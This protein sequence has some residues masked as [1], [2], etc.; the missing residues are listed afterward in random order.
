MS[1]KGLFLVSAEDRVELWR[2]NDSG[3]SPVGWAEIK[4]TSLSGKGP[5]SGSFTDARSS[6]GT[7]WYGIHVVDT[8]GQ[9]SPEPSPPGPIKV[10]VG[11]FEVIVDDLNSG[12]SKYG[13]PSYWHE[14]SIGYNGH[15]F[16]TYNNQSTID[17]YSRW[18]P[19]LSTGGAGTYAVYVYIPNN[20]ANTTNATYTIFHNG[21]V[22]T[23]AIN[24]N[25]YYNQWVLLGSFYFS[26]NGSEY[27]QLVDKT[28][29]TAVTKMIGFD[30][31]KWVK[32]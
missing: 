14:A 25:I 20:Y 26:A 31:V 7:Y 15:M 28:G 27:V 18:Q 10:T 32:Q 21:A 4:R 23:R 9:W 13:T 1:T 19:N 30:A 16:W 5:S 8:K 2:A 11:T 22:D 17:N 29:E 24:Q 3:G 12:F 6:A